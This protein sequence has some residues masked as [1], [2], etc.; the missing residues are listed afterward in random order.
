MTCSVVYHSI[1]RSLLILL[2]QHFNWYCVG[3]PHHPVFSLCA[4]F[5]IDCFDNEILHDF[6][7]S[8]AYIIIQYLLL[9][10]CFF[11]C[12]HLGIIQIGSSVISRMGRNRK[13]G[14]PFR[15][16]DICFPLDNDSCVDIFFAYRSWDTCSNF[17]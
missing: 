5:F 16:C 17:C 14:S 2:V 11:F 10:L 4:P 1:S 6:N 13:F 9:V 3:E 7:D 12:P 15:H 8:S